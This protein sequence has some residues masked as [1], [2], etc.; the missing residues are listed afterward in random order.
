MLSNSFLFWVRKYEEF[1][2]HPIVC[3]NGEV[4]IGY[5]RNIDNGITMTE[6]G[7]MFEHDLEIIYLKLK[8]FS[9][10]FDKPVF[11][12]DA[13]MHLCYAVSFEQFLYMEDLIDHIK[14]SDYSSAAKNILDIRQQWNIP[15]HQDRL[16]DIAL[17]I[18]EGARN[19]EP[20]A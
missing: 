1:N 10:F 12:Q 16:K 4:R 20:A 9:W 2:S 11:V 8:P 3:A 6:A 7:I 5:G 13:I 18:S 19:H 15:V 17:L 14:K